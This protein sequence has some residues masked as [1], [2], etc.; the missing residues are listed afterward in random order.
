[1]SLREPFKMKGIGYCTIGDAEFFFQR[2]R[3]LRVS[4]YSIHDTLF[5]S[6]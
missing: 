2:H 3:Y 5:L 4:D 1:M 6:P